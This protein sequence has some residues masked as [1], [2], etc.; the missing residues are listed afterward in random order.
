M[1][2]DRRHP[3]VRPLLLGSG[4][5][6]IATAPVVAVLPGPAGTFAF[7]AG[8]GLVLRN[9]FGARRRFVL[10]KRRWPRAGRLADRGLRRASAR[11][12]AERAADPR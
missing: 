1:A 5:A 7:V 4:I 3:L 12:R 6:L 8:L 2:A 9:S 11:R 10:A